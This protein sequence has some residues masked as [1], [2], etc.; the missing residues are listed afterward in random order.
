MGDGSSKRVLKAIGR[1]VALIRFD[2]ART[3][4]MRGD[5]RHHLAYHIGRLL[6]GETTAESEWE[7]FD[8]AIEVEPD[9]DGAPES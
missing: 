2:P 1:T 9:S 4:G 5:E 6:T 7:H 8:I 3:G